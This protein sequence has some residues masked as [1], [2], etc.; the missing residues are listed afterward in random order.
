MYILAIETTGATASVALV[1]E[2]GLMGH[3][4]S[5]EKMNHLQNLMPM[6]QKLLVQSKLAIDDITHIGV[7]EGPGSFT[8]IRIG[9]STAR[10]LAQA[11][12]LPIIPVP[13]LTAFAYHDKD[14]KGIFCPIFDARREQIYGGAFQW[15]SDGQEI[16]EIIPGNA[17]TIQEMLEKL[18]ELAKGQEIMFFGD[19]IHAYETQIQEWAQTL[20]AKQIKIQMAPPSQRFQNASSVG[21]MA[22][23]LFQEGKS[24]FFEEVHPVY[25][26]KAEAQRKLEEGL[27]HV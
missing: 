11:L 21:E 6:I 17:Y 18:E 14:Y 2:E 5:E 23:R 27:L 26:R 19:G 20:E 8:G 15:A 3:E 13:T 4:W 24:V 1:N 10:G 7:S 25:M 16:L 12:N 9:I 22:L